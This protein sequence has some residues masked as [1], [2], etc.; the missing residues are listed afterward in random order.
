MTSEKED[1]NIRPEVRKIYRSI[2]LDVIVITEDKLRICLSGSFKKVEKKKDWIAPFGIL[3][4][5]LVAL[6][7]STFQNFIFEGATWQ[8]VFILSAVISGIWLVLSLNKARKSL[9]VEDII[10]D[11]KQN[12]Q[13]QG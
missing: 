4:T 6:A 7:T 9:R 5:I 10:R 2:D 8:A 13:K 12:S 11:L 3:I 1:I